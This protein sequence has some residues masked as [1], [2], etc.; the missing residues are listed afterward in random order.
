MS[1][2]KVKGVGGVFNAMDDNLINKR[3]RRNC[4]EMSSTRWNRVKPLVHVF[5]RNTLTEGKA[6]SSICEFFHTHLWVFT[7]F[8]GLLFLPFYNSMG[9]LPFLPGSLGIPFEDYFFCTIY[10]II[11][12]LYKVFSFS[13]IVGL[14]PTLCDPS[15]SFARVFL[16][17]HGHLGSIRHIIWSLSWAYFCHF[18]SINTL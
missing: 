1:S 11:L 13:F 14:L 16:W 3:M 18:F 10:R 15:T 8:V 17:N 9:L 5:Q 2:W 4:G 12:T 7:L 6:T